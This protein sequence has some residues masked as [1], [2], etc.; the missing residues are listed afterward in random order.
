M[1]PWLRQFRAAFV[2]SLRAGKWQHCVFTQPCH[3]R[4]TSEEN[5][6][7]NLQSPHL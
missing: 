1:Q 7:N 3:L 2:G 5:L 4:I 6:W